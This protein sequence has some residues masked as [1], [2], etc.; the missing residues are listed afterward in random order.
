MGADVF[1]L[2]LH[3]SEVLKESS[4]VFSNLELLN[5]NITLALA[6]RSVVFGL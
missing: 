2:M 1:E 6:L 3:N 5:A 4:T